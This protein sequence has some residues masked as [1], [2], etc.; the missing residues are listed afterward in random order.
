[1]GRPKKQFSLYSRKN[2]SG[3]KIWY[4]RTYDEFGK[5]T[6]GKSTGQTS[7]TKAESYCIELLKENNL[8]PSSTMKLVDYVKMKHFFE[9]GVCEYS[10][11]N[12][13]KETYVNDCSSR[14]TAHILPLLGD[15]RF[16]TL[17]HK[18][19][20]SWQRFLL[21]SDTKTLS[22]KTVRECKTVLKII[23]KSALSDGYLTKDIFQRVKKL[24]QHSRK[25]RGILTELEVRKLFA[26]NSL[27]DNWNNHIYYFT[28]SLLACFTGLRQ[29]EILALTPEKIFE[30]HIFVN[31]S[32]G[33]NGIG[34]TK[35]GDKRKVYVKKEVMDLIRNI[36]PESGYIF[37]MSYGNKPISGNRLTENLYKALENI[38]IS[39]ENRIERN[40]TFHSFRHWFVTY[41]R[42]KG[43]TDTEITSMTGQKTPSV[44]DDYTRYDLIEHKNIVGALNSF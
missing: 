3:K 24:P 27:K 26:A 36:M 35:T 40:I 7:K 9:Y 20:E 4:Y 41:L 10:I 14:M 6:T 18:H 5:R 11:D 31:A 23:L 44:I 1:M 33:K 30:K 8:I 13:L 38:G 12:T 29:G 21:K 34:T 37:S 25:V 28:A 19:I 43:I 2:S 42:N 32:Y 15:I 22:I 39:K 17:S 16:D